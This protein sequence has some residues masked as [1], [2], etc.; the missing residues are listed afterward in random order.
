MFFFTFNFFGKTCH[1]WHIFHP[2]LYKVEF[3]VT[4]N[5]LIFTICFFVE[6]KL[7]VPLENFLIFFAIFWIFNKCALNMFSFMLFVVFFLKY[8]IIYYSMLLDQLVD[9][10][11]H[12]ILIFLPIPYVVSHI[13]LLN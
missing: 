5:A 6:K 2:V 11:G 12:A 4:Q 10:D 8:P 3:C 1:V 13:H 7:Q 9:M